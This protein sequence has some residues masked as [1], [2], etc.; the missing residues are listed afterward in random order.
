MSSTNEWHPVA[1]LGDG[2]PDPQEGPEI[3]FYVALLGNVVSLCK[4]CYA[5]LEPEATAADMR[6]FG[7]TWSKTSWS[8][9]ECDTCGETNEYT[10]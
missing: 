2:V 5:E 3:D 9:M 4:A 6:M 8:D 1:W 7:D 10:R